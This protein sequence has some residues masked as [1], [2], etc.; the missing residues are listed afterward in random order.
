MRDTALIA[1]KLTDYLPDTEGD[2]IG[3]DKG[4]LYLAKRKIRMVFAVGD[5]DSVT[6]DEMILIRQYADEVI[7]LSPQKDDSDS[8]SAVRH[9][10][11]RGYKKIILCG[12]FGGRIDHT[13]VNLCLAE[14]YPGTVVLQDRRNKVVCCEEGSRIFGKDYS[15][16]SF[17]ARTEAV[18]SLRGMKYP[19]EERKITADD[20][21]TLSNEI[22]GETGEIIVHS[23]KIIVMQCRD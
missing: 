12:C 22:E 18:V 14:K 11:E 13:Y 8:E 4:A 15:Y 19:L 7:Q 17:F 16:I 20:I 3:A 5:F 23:G 2:Y 6:A 10:L 21:Y 9:C 1:L